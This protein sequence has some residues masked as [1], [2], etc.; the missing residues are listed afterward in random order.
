MVQEQEL[1]AST[2]DL[3]PTPQHLATFASHLHLAPLGASTL[4]GRVI[5]SALWNHSS[6]Y[7]SLDSSIHPPHDLGKLFNGSELQFPYM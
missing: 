6:L 7:S 5:K 1:P 4:G 2:R 3:P